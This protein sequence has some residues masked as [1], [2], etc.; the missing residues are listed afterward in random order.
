MP[1][2]TESQEVL[3]AQLEEKVAELSRSNRELEQF[4]Y[5]ASH[6][7]QEP[8]RMVTAFVDL[9]DT[10]YGDL[11]RDQAGDGALYLEHIKA[12]SVRAKALID[13]LLAF[14]RVGQGMRR[15]WFS[16]RQAVDH[17]MEILGPDTS[18]RG[19]RVT[20]VDPLPAV[21]ADLQM[22]SRLFTN[23]IGNSLKY[24]SPA[25]QPEITI[26]AEELDSYY[27]FRVTDNGLGFH[28]R[29]ATKVFEIFKRLRTDKNGAGI[30][31]A[32][33][34][35]IVECHGGEI[36]AVSEEGVGTTIAF[37]LPRGET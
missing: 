31:L 22:L 10:E 16:A 11:I 6:D 7:L 18:E 4:A 35:K 34:Q 25:R 15:E 14:S 5:V 9:L 17:A 2:I 28:P 12:G 21:Y 23:I 30:G 20:V 26:N 19:A 36:L 32:I 33:C 29:Y 13:A 27:L 24:R 37:S 8:L 1:A 3:K